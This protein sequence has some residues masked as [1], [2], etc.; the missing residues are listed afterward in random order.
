MRYGHPSLEWDAFAV[1]EERRPQR[2]SGTWIT[3]IAG[4]LILG[5]LFALGWLL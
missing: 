4:A 5:G 2:I 1:A 3:V